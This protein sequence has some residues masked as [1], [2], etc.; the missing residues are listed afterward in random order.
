[1]PDLAAL[2]WALHRAH[3]APQADGL[4]AA[5]LAAIAPEQ[6]EASRFRLHPAVQLLA[7]EWAVAPLWLAHQPGSEVAFPEEMAVPGLALVARP[8]WQPVVLPLDAAAYA[9]LQVMA[10][11]GTLGAALDAAFERDAAFD[12]AAALQQ[13]LAQAVLV[14]WREEA[15]VS[16]RA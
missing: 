7:S 15:G 12:V 8:H 11:G 6:I 10:Q 5:Q 13:W 14:A 9:A 3:Y 4:S 1:L 16:C 2:E